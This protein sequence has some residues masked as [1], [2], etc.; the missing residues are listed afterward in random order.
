MR[1]RRWLVV[2]VL[3]AAVVATSTTELPSDV[4]SWQPSALAGE[5]V[6]SLL[7]APD[8][9]GDGG[10]GDV[11]V[12]TRTQLYRMSP[13]G[14]VRALDVPGPVRAMTASGDGV[15][16]GTE[17]GLLHLASETD[18][19]RVEALAGVQVLALSA[20][21]D[22]LVVGAGDGL[23]RRASDG[24]LQR[25]WPADAGSGRAVEAVLPAGEGVLFAHP[26]GLALAG[27]DGSVSV[28]VPGISVVSLGRWDSDD[29]LWAGT[30]GGP[31][32]LVSEDGGATW[33]ER[34]DGLGFSAVNAIA[35]D[36]ADGDRIVA[37]G[38]GLADGTGNAGTQWSDDDGRTWQV[39]QDRLSNTHVYAL[40]AQRDSLRVH[41]SPPGPVAPS[42]VPLPLDTARWY[43]GTNG[44]GVSTY[45][46]DVPALTALRATAPALRVLEPLVAGLLLLALLVP[47]YQHLKRG[48]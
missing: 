32:L 36:P 45:R 18:A 9:T 28:L 22:A 47:A 19:A 16:L 46:P 11:L 15:W 34:G 24:S 35:R 6:F 7:G 31:L 20:H 21:G 44:S 48:R 26:D 8:G 39:R 14:A 3:G 38:S 40:L 41:L 27:S 30:R 13:S 43:A 29:E 4:D 12:G 10:A 25:M 37:G 42:A 5:V 2:G 23:H 33:D 1:T 17:Q